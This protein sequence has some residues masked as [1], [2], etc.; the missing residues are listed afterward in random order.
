MNFTGIE[1]VSKHPEY[2]FSKCTVLYVHGFGTNQLSETVL[3]MKEAYLLHG[4]YN[5]MAL[6][7]AKEA[8]APN[9]LNAFNNVA[10]VICG[11]LKQNE[12][13]LT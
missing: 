5:F 6:D 4:G 2:D 12:Y 13:E 8:A 7:W 10:K 11:L 3:L 1:E 9:Y